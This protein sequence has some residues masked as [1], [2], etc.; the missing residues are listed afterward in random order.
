VH[1]LS[2]GL[3]PP[4]EPSSHGFR[5]AFGFYAGTR[6]EE[7]VGKRERIVKLR[8]AGEVAHTEIVKPIEG[9]GAPLGTHDDFDAELV[10][11]H[12]SSITRG[13]WGKRTS[14][15]PANFLPLTNERTRINFVPDRAAWRAQQLSQTLGLPTTYF[16]V[17]YAP[18]TG[19]T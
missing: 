4:G 10:S 9:A 15:A 19:T 14:P 6:F 1:L 16:F 13:S 18:G 12:E 7:A 8:L 2:L 17:R 11:E 5:Q 3:A